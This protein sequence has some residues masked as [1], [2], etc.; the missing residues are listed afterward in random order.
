MRDGSEQDAVSRATRLEDGWWKRRAVAFQ[1]RDADLARVQGEVERQRALYAVEHLQCGAG[2]LGTDAVA[3]Q[4]DQ[5]HTNLLRLN[6]P[7]RGAGQ[8]RADVF[9]G[10]PIGYAVVLD[11]DIAEV[12]REHD[13]VE[14][15]QRMVG[16]QR[17]LVVD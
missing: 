5:M 7:K 4:D 16:R 9:D 15:T 10:L 17:L 11:R 12:R 8:K 3:R 2:D 6:D 13:V 14:V 1:R